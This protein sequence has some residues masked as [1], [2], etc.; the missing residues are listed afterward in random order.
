ALRAK[1]KCPR[2]ESVMRGARSQIQDSRYMR[3]IRR[4]P[5]LDPQ[6]EYVLAKRWRDRGDRA[7]ADRL[8]TSHL[9]LVSKIALGY[10]GYGLP[11][12]EVISEGNVGLM[13]A[14][15]RFDPD[16]GFRLATYAMWW[17]KA[18]IRAYILR[19]WSLVKIGTTASERKLFF[20]LRQTKSSIA[21]L[22]EGDLHPEQVKFIADHLGVAA[23]DVIQMNSRIGGDVS[24]NA[25]TQYEGDS[26]EW[27]AWLV[28]EGA[29]QEASLAESEET[30][31]RRRALREA[32]T[33]LKDRERLIFEARRLADDP[34]SLDELGVELGLSPERV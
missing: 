32:L 7:A 28:D 31:S 23:E 24:L 27:Q 21:A 30:E 20:K 2:E 10:R 5:L 25:P 34:M 13:Q 19:S 18:A 11:M 29:S 26:S 22:S 4:F 6:E 3:D 33:V 15:M 1:L 12:S 8:V 9:R 16:K 17:I 14:V